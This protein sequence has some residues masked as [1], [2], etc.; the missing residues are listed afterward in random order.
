MMYWGWS[1]NGAASASAI[2]AAS[3]ALL[4]QLQLDDLRASTEI[5]EFLKMHRTSGGAFSTTQVNSFKHISLI[6]SDSYK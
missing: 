5:A 4:A 2:E 1:G 3:Y 6:H